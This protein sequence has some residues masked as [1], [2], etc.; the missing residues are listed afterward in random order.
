MITLYCML[1][2]REYITLN[3]SSI[4]YRKPTPLAITL[5]KEIPNWFT[6]NRIHN[7]N[8]CNS[9]THVMVIMLEK[10]IE[11]LLKETRPINIITENATIFNWFRMKIAQDIIPLDKIRFKFINSN[12][13][14]FDLD[15]N[16]YG[17]CETYDDQPEFMDKFWGL[18]GD[19]ASNTLRAA[20][21]KRKLERHLDTAIR[22]LRDK[23]STE[24][25]RKEFADYVR[26]TNKPEPNVFHDHKLGND[27]I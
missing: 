16:K 27:C 9:S 26:E 15:I 24:E 23:L 6:D 19:I 10:S 4:N 18:D 11:E 12:G 5:E 20:M 8:M 22:N 17:R 25:G 2:N 3:P 7:I 1:E 14:I 21:N 13:S